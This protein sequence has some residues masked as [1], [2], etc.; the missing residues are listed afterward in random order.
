M[1][2]LHLLVAMKIMY[3]NMLL[4]AILATILYFVDKWYHIRYPYRVRNYD[5]QLL[6]LL[7]II[8][9][10]LFILEAGK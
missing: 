5:T 6:F 9:W 8:A 10:S 1:L 4:A 7:M 2:R 3:F